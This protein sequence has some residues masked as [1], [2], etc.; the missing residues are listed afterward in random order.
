MQYFDEE[1][2]KVAI[3]SQ[4]YPEYYLMAFPE[5]VK[6]GRHPKIPVRGEVSGTPGYYLPP[7]IWNVYLF[8]GS[9][10]GE[11]GLCAGRLKLLGGL[12]TLLSLFLF[13]LWL[14]VQQEAFDLRSADRKQTCTQP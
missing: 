1:G 10:D 11:L 14:L 7:G 9:A 6:P 5:D 4:L 3:Q 8:I 13:T 12:V 2:T